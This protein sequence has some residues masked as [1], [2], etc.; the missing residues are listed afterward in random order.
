MTID[1]ICELMKKSKEFGVRHF[2]LD[3]AGEHIEME[4][5][6]VES[7][8]KTTTSLIRPFSTS[9]PDIKAEDLFKPP[10]HLSDDVLN[11]PDKVLYYATNF[12]DDLIAKEED[13]KNQIDQQIS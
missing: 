13:R 7:N 11:N 2:K 6:L 9:V 10:A 8:S 5:S 12:Y 3:L 1:E 4:L